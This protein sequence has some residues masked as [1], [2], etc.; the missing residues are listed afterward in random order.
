[1][2]RWDDPYGPPLL[3]ALLALALFA[4]FVVKVVQIAL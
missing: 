3:A 4:I 1:M 2:C